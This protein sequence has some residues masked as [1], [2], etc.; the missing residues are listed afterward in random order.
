MTIL[1]Q[2]FLSGIVAAVI[3]AT[4]GFYIWANVAAW[5]EGDCE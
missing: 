4:I 5:A 1:A 2:V 3:V